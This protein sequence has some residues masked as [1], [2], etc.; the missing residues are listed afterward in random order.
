MRLMWL[1][2]AVIAAAAIGGGLRYVMAR[3]TARGLDAAN[4]LGCAIAGVAVG[5]GITDDAATVLVMAGCGSLT[6]LSA[7]LVDVRS[8]HAAAGAVARIVT[9][10]AVVAT[11]AMIAG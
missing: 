8:I 11:A 10:V 4:L 1:V 3:A 7:V 2:P 5:R 9:G 6:S